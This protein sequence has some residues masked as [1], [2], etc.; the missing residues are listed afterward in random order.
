MDAARTQADLAHKQL[1]E[2]KRLFTEGMKVLVQVASSDLAGCF[3]P[4][5]RATVTPMLET[6]MA[7]ANGRGCETIM[8]VSN[9]IGQTEPRRGPDPPD[10]ND[11]QAKA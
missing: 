4:L 10:E 7:H 8:W 1:L 3:E 9:I 6:M 11:D 2:A 5:A